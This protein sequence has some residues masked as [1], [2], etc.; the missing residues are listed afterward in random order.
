[1]YICLVVPTSLHMEYHTNCNF[2][3]NRSESAISSQPESF[4]CVFTSP[5][6]TTVSKSLDQL[7]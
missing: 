5:Q 2:I 6:K 4:K 1:M 3:I 7:R